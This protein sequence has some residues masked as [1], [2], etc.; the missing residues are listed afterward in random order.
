[1]CKSDTSLFAEPAPTHLYT[2]KYFIRKGLISDKIEPLPKYSADTLT[3]GANF[4]IEP[5]SATPS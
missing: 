5:H 3:K 1:M 2:I 4:G